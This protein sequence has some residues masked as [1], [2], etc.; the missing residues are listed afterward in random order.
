MPILCLV[1]FSGIV[2]CIGGP[3]GSPP[4]Q[5]HPVELVVNNSATERH[6]FEVSV[7]ELPANVTTQRSD[8]LTATWSIGEGVGS[9]NPGDNY[10]YTAVELPDSAQVHDRYT[11]SPDEE[12]QSSIEDLPRD[13]AIIVVVYQDEGEIISWVSANCAD[14]ALVGLKVSS[15]P[16]G[17]TTAHSCQ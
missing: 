7:V 1:V 2:G 13:F 8:G 14:L 16:H 3:F 9:T 17:V 4:G 11:L 12:N 10:T 5:E 15:Q 6:T